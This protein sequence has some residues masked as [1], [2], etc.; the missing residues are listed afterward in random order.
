MPESTLNAQ[1][2][3]ETYYAKKAFYTAHLHN[4]LAEKTP[5]EESK[6]QKYAFQPKENNRLLNI[7]PSLEMPNLQ[8]LNQN[9]EAVAKAIADIRKTEEQEKH[10][11][12]KKK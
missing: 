12:K 4:A 1:R 11:S 7:N 2:Q 6:P 10:K 9:Y 3:I 8:G 5:S